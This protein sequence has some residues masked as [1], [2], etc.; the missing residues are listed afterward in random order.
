[1]GR[2]QNVIPICHEGNA[3][4]TLKQNI[5][6][7]YSGIKSACVLWVS[8]KLLDPKDNL[9]KDT[10]WLQCLRGLFSKFCLEDEQWWH[11]CTGDTGLSPFWASPRCIL[12][13]KYDHISCTRKDP[14]P[15][16]GRYCTWNS[17]GSHFYHQLLA[18]RGSLFLIER[19]LMIISMRAFLGLSL[20]FCYNTD[21]F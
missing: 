4:H 11:F 2:C 15:K 20:P 13:S 8:H 17:L 5:W 1:M 3:A 14:K 10:L 12:S 6:L 16:V 7:W 21:N 9:Q 19:R 18:G